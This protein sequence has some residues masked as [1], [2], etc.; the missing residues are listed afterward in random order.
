MTSQFLNSDELEDATGARQPKV[1]AEVLDENGVY[2]IVRRDG[3]I[4][5]TWHHINNPLRISVNSQPATGINFDYLESKSD[6]SKKK[7]TE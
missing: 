5:V 2:Y 4:R 7:S 3:K 1:Q 6:G